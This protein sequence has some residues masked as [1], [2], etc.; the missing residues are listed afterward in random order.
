LIHSDHTDI[1]TKIYI[2]L[3]NERKK[4][5]KIEDTLAIHTFNG[6]DRIDSDDYERYQKNKN[7]RPVRCLMK[8]LKNWKNYS[9]RIPTRSDHEIGLKYVDHGKE[10]YELI[11]N[12]TT[13]MKSSKHV[14]QMGL[15]EYKRIT[16]EILKLTC[17]KNLVDAYKSIQT[18]KFKDYDHLKKY[19]TQTILPNLID[20]CKDVFPKIPKKFPRIKVQKLV[21]GTSLAYY[22]LPQ[23]HCKKSNKSDKGKVVIQVEDIHKINVFDLTVLIAHEIFPGHFYQT[24][25]WKTTQFP[26]ALW[27]VEGYAL[28][29]ESIVDRLGVEY[30]IMRLF[31]RLI[32]AARCIIDPK[33]HIGGISLSKAKKLY[34][35]LLPHLSKQ[36]VHLDI[37]RY[38][39]MPGQSCTYLAGCMRIEKWRSQFKGKTSTFYK[40]FL[41]GG[42]GPVQYIEAQLK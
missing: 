38:T 23:F 16:S 5:K 37:L 35:H 3:Y 18:K 26:P 2:K 33:I 7:I 12:Q 34:S 30:K 31:Q 14:Y 4:F 9:T 17:K 39:A 27:Y 13:G 15:R 10:L 32:R 19:I 24:Y 36:M 22:V 41:Q 21:P 1:R 6:I 20:V 40:R 28:S 42:A 11:I 25:Q 8:L 29:I